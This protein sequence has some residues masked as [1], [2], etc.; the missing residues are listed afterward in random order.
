V[1]SYRDPGTGAGFAEL[2]DLVSR[3]GGIAWIRF[4]TSHPRDRRPEISRV[5]ANRPTVCRQLHLPLQSGSSAVLGRMNR[6]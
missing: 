1:N 6:G 2:L 5:M 3:V 4:L